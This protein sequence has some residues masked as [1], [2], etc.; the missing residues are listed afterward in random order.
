MVAALGGIDVLSFTGGIGEN[1]PAVRAAACKG[2]EFLDLRVDPKLNETGN[3]DRDI[4]DPD[5]RVRIYVFHTHEEWIIARACFSFS[6][7]K[8]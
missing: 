1:S 8:T 3:F 2:L 7:G 5:S 6:E 4:A